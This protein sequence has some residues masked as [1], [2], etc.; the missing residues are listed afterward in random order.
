M[1]ARLVF[2]RMQGKNYAS[3]DEATQ[4]FGDVAKETLFT[5]EIF[6]NYVL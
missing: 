2:I 4:M 1:F 6:K 3:A 5:R